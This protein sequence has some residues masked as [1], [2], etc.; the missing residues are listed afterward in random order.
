[1][2]RKVSKKQPK[3]S[4][5]FEYFI[6]ANLS[7][8]KGQYVALLGK[9]VIASGTNAKEVWEKAKKK[10]RGKLPTLA[11]LPQEEVL[12]LLWK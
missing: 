1:M 11:K 10:S 5:E 2:R 4:P 7:R 12:I 8:Y 9:K 6:K 3:T